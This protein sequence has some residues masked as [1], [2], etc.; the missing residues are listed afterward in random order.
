MV[1]PC[2]TKIVFS[3]MD[4]TLL[5]SQKE[6]SSVTWRALDCLADAGVTFVPCS[7]RALAGIP[8]GLVSH[9]ATR[10]VV[11]ANGASIFEIAEGKATCI[12]HETM[13]SAEVL[14]IHDL[15]RDTDGYFD[16]FIDGT[17][18]VERRRYELLSRYVPDKPMLAY[19][20]SVRTPID[21]DTAVRLLSSPNGVEKVSIFCDG[22]FTHAQMTDYLA[23]HDDFACLSSYNDNIEITRATATK[24]HALGLICEREGIDVSSS[25]A[26]GDAMN[27]STMLVAAGDG[28]AMENASEEVKDLADHVTDTNDN[29]GVARY[30]FSLL[31]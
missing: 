13:D 5:N 12:R 31:G 29:N 30:L 23:H 28:I 2:R 25:V 24:G 22:D 15:V 4:G 14:E 27:D 21:D 1:Q 8:S 19:M 3:D 17:I 18:Y 11:A 26:F 10:F 7:G 6:V 16:F 20:R 9:P